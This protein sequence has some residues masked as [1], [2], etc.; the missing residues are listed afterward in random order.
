MTVND[1]ARVGVFVMSFIGF[2]LGT[3]FIGAMMS[4]DDPDYIP[5]ASWIVGMI[6]Y[7]FTVTFMWK[8]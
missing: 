4:L 3:G 5:L 1:L 2:A 7:G 8:V 6:V